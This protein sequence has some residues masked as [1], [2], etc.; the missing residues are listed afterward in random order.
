[1]SKLLKY[2][3]KLS[4]KKARL[5]RWPLHESNDT[6]LLVSLLLLL[7]IVFSAML[8]GERQKRKKEGE[9]M[10]NKKVLSTIS[11]PQ[12]ILIAF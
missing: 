4:I 12:L 10:Q 5:L 8:V 2:C 11:N 1:M 7:F 3:I 6:C 9:A